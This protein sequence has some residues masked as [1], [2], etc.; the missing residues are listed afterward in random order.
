MWQPYGEERDVDGHDVVGRTLLALECVSNLLAEQ[1]QA[2][3]AEGR[4]PERLA[5]VVT[6]MDGAI[7][8][9]TSGRRMLSQLHESGED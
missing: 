4:S 7:D 8:H 5:R 6:L 2:L 1:H 3:Q 9:L